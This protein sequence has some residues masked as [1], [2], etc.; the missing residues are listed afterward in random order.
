MYFWYISLAKATST[1]TDQIERIVI[2]CLK[3]VTDNSTIIATIKKYK[4]IL[5]T[6]ESQTPMLLIFG[7]SSS[8]M[9]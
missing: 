5:R 9:Q 6:A 8:T 1:K 2:N 4:A 7:L 3:S